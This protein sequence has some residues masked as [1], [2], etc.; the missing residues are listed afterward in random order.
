MATT[1]SAGGAVGARAGPA[2]IGGGGANAP[3]LVAARAPRRGLAA[4]LA[5]SAFSVG[6]G[7]AEPVRL[8]APVSPG[9]LAAA[10]STG[11]HAGSAAGRAPASAPGSSRA[12]AELHAPAQSAA[13]L[14]DG[15][16]ARQDRGAAIGRSRRYRLSPDAG[17]VLPVPIGA[18]AQRVWRR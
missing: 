18:W 8:V 5:T 14:A 16:P 3:E 11:E 15:D 4:T 6:R 1:D 17:A 2:G 9:G 7:C 13:R 10:G 12:P